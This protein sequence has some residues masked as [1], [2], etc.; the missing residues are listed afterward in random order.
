M[1]L[2]LN[3][4]DEKAQKTIK[5]LES[6]TAADYEEDVFQMKKLPDATKDITRDVDLNTN[7]IGRQRNLERFLSLADA[8]TVRNDFDRAF[9]T[10]ESA[11]NTLGNHPEIEKRKQL[12]KKRFQQT[13]QPP[14]PHIE[15]VEL[16]PIPKSPKVV[17]LENLLQRVNAHREKDESDLF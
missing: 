15:E 3:P 16:P 2:F 8:Y 14:P 1:V 13:H 6:L 7:S 9:E 12:L 4:N 10:L 11:E 17:L 5:K